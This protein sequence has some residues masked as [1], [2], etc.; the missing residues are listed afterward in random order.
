MDVIIGL[1]AELFL[2][3]VL[4]DRQRRALL[5]VIFSGLPEMETGVQFLS[6]HHLDVASDVVVF[7]LLGEVLAD[8]ERRRILIVLFKRRCARL[9]WRHWLS[10]I[11]SRMILNEINA[12][13]ASRIRLLLR[14]VLHDGQSSLLILI[15]QFIKFKSSFLRLYSALSISCSLDA[16]LDENEVLLFILLS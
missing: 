13:N 15:F 12:R 9:C 2:W 6:L 5:T 4:H 7:F 10:F 14:E 1:V 8:D 16:I 11:H 3:E